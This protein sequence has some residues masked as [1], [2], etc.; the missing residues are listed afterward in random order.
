MAAL[1][2][3]YRRIRKPAGFQV[4]WQDLGPPRLDVSSSQ[5][6]DVKF[7]YGSLLERITRIFQSMDDETQEKVLQAYRE[8]HGDGAYAYAK[9]TIAAWKVRPPQQVGQT[10]M[11]L[12]DVVPLF[13][14]LQTKFE[15]AYI[16][17]EETMRRLRQLRMTI[18]VSTEDDL[19]SAMER[20]KEVIDTQLEVE[21]P[22]GVIETRTWL[23]KDDAA[24]FEEMH[25]EA[26][27]RILYE[28]AKDFF[29]TVR[30]LQQIRSKIRIPVGILAVFELP[31]AQITF[32]IVQASRGPMSD[33]NRGPM[34]EELLTTHDDSGLLARWNDL[35]LETR[36][37]SGDVSYPEYVLRNMDK[38]FS[39][40][41]QAELHKIAAM[42]GLELER[43]LMEI[44]IKSRT[45][46]ADLQKL[47]T[48][49]RTLQ[50]KKIQ[51]DVVSRHETPSGHIEI[52]ARSRRT[53]G[54]L[55][56]GVMLVTIII[57]L[58]H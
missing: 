54:C 33:E 1:S 55:P 42:H 9:R 43:L 44:Q 18:E 51:A 17:R 35:E 28:Q 24:F 57:I 8:V 48:T 13:V 5:F 39:E 25:K 16:V 34:S 52:S 27:R 23:S 45:S 26:D 11:R 49:L 15:L 10:I 19:Q 32:R 50:E 30:T 3:L 58:L 40:E 56:I 4:R 38:F 6:R 46:E 14:D 7:K 20:V 53:V 29:K 37:K 41:Q 12:L 2:D 21:L 36:F 31:T 22:P 47:L